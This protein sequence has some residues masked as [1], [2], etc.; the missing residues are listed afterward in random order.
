MNTC[1]SIN[2]SRSS[3]F[4]IW[5]IQEPTITCMAATPKHVTKSRFHCKHANAKRYRNG[6]KVD[7]LIQYCFIKTFLA[8]IE[9][10]L[11]SEGLQWVALK[12]LRTAF[13]KITDLRHTWLA[14]LNA[15]ANES[16]PACFVFEKK[17][18][19]RKAIKLAGHDTHAQGH[20]PFTRLT[21]WNHDQRNVRA[22]C[23]P[24]ARWKLFTYKNPTKKNDTKSISEM[25]GWLSIWNLFRNQPRPT[26]GV[27]RAKSTSR[28]SL[29]LSSLPSSTL[30]TTGNARTKPPPPVPYRKHK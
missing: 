6:N 13:V 18:N 12:P 21:Y 30:N 28:A 5:P 24:L 16:N 11:L 10:C 25:L 17:K 7:S 27:C 26:N 1:V 19:S 3:S 15:K 23:L 20:S 29:G 4:D 22:L 2:S 9:T 14:L 8:Q